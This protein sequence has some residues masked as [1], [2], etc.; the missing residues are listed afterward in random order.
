MFLL[1]EMKKKSN[2]FISSLLQSQKSRL[3]YE[4]ICLKSGYAK[5]NF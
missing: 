3:I 4:N 1:R 5:F 2:L